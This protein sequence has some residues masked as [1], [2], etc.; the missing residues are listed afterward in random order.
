MQEHKV[1][2]L[3]E[4]L[5]NHN[6]VVC[7]SC[8]NHRNSKAQSKGIIRIDAVANRKFF[9]PLVQL[10]VVSEAGIQVEV[11]IQAVEVDI[12]AVEVDIQAERQPEKLPRSHHSWKALAG[13]HNIVPLNYVYDHSETR[14]C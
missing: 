12:Q 13:L 5:D 9:V 14:L 6:C 2:V 8:G 10:V 7:A 3:A 4:R 1:Q 11:D